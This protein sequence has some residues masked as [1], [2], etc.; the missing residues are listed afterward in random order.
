MRIKLSRNIVAR[1]IS[2]TLILFA[3]WIASLMIIAI[4]VPE[5]LRNHRKL[6]GGGT[7]V[8]AWALANFVIVPLMWKKHKAEHRYILKASTGRHHQKTEYT[9]P[10]EDQ[11]EQTQ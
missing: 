1:V 4:F 7:F 5:I 2:G 3:I 6:T 8:F 10:P 11:P 9:D